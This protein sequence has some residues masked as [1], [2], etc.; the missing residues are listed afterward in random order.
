MVIQKQKKPVLLILLSVVIGIVLRI[1]FQLPSTISIPIYVIS[2]AR[3]QDRRERLA[4][5][6]KG[7]P[8]T[9]RDAVDG[10]NLT[11]EQEKLA[12]ERVVPG[13]LLKGQI[14]CFLSHY[15]LWK[16]LYHNNTPYTVILEDDILLK[17]P[18][19]E[20]VNKLIKIKGFEFDIL[21]L[22]HLDMHRGWHV[23][24]LGNYS[25]YTCKS[26]LATH[27]YIVSLSGLEKLVRYVEETKIKVPIDILILEKVQ[28][29]DLLCLCAHPTMI[30]AG[31]AWNS[32]IEYGKN[33]T[34]AFWNPV[35]F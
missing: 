20:T 5:V 10:S 6:M 13:T 7:I 4:S 3:S 2:L 35:G 30:D 21:Y 12:E 27:G 16:Q 31:Y 28:Q 23:K 18:L 1:R 15:I 19:I 29:G 8:F 11:I 26:P 22:G 9:L 25:I 32:T 33:D 24:T 34:E 17:V 14:G